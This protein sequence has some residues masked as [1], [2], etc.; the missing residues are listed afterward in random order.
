MPAGT[1]WERRDSV[2]FGF[3]GVLGFAVIVIAWY[4]AS[5]T[6][7]AGDG[8]VWF[9]VGLGGLALAGIADAVWFLRGR[10]A[11]GIA[12]ALILPGV[13][14]PEESQ[15]DARPEWSDGRRL[16]AGA[17]MSRFH[18]TDCA[19]VGGR[20]LEAASRSDHLLAGLQPCEVCE[21]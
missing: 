2:F 3:A 17:G 1:P 21:P 11:V 10:R 15:P 12:R 6:L 8:W 9:N 7:T 13:L 20:A 18:R 16:V 5:T 14:G 4:G 19:F